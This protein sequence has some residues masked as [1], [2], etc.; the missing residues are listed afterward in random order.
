LINKI[1]E[2]GQNINDLH[3]QISDLKE[4][5]NLLANQVQLNH[6]SIQEIQHKLSVK[7]NNQPVEEIHSTPKEL[8]TPSLIPITIY[9]VGEVMKTLLNPLRSFSF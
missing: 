2:Q 6:D 8:D 3:N 1:N 4:S 7:I 5:N 9:G